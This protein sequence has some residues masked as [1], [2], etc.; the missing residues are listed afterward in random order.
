M[1]VRTYDK[2]DFINYS[3]IQTPSGAA[4]VTFTQIQDG[5]WQIS[6]NE[7]YPQ[8][9]TASSS[10]GTVVEYGSL[11]NFI[12]EMLADWD[13]SIF[14]TIP[15]SSLISEVRVKLFGSLSVSVANGVEAADGSSC[16]AQ[17]V[18]S[19]GAFLHFPGN[20]SVP[21]CDDIAMVLDTPNA[22]V[23]DSDAGATGASASVLQ[24]ITDNGNNTQIFDFSSSPI[25]KA[26]FETLFGSL[27]VR[28]TDDGS[29]PWPS[30]GAFGSGGGGL[31]NSPT[32]TWSAVNTIDITLIIENV[33]MQV[34][35][36]SGPDI[37]L[38]PSGGD[39]EP[40]Q[41]ITVTG[42]NVNILAYAALFGNQVIPIIPKIIGPDE[43]VLEV[44][45]PDADCADCFDDCPECEDC[46]DACNEDLTGDACQACMQACLDCLVECLDDLEAGED[47][48]ASADSP[49]DDEIPIVIICGGP[50]FTGS[51]PLGN[52]T[53][54]VARAS[55]IYQ[56]LD[57]KD[58]DTLY[59]TARDG[60]TY[61]VKIPNPNAKTGFFRS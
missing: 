9:G 21:Y 50:R 3:C 13:F 55:G 8:G 26:E 10:W 53:I 38:S 32:D 6:A 54:L 12:V 44:P 17:S 23:I 40:G 41:S 33:Q 43:V 14:P 25:T 16:T 48:Q 5:N 31:Q 56:L 36:S 58:S 27:A 30:M 24:N 59:A 52:F 22:F 11:F 46:F 61:D 18:S 2:L 60:T 28:T 39:V 42:D 57:G 4:P 49:P 47:C 7:T 19:I 45:S 35:Y 34:T 29:S 20:P 37:T 15:D 1:P 51:V